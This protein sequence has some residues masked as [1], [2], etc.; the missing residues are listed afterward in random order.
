MLV[1][2]WMD[3]AAS[4]QFFVDACKQS[5]H[6][7]APDLRGFGQSEW[8][9]EG[10]SGYWFADY[11]ADL[12]AL[13]DEVSP[14]APVHL[15][16]HS[17]GGNIVSMYAGVR[18]HR[19]AKLISLDGFGVPR[20]T[21]DQAPNKLAAWLDAVRAPP[22]LQSYASL[23]RVAERLVKNNPRLTPERAA[24]I[25]KHWAEP[26]ADGSYA[27]RADPAH[28]LPFPTV[29][30]LE[31]SLAIW[32]KVSAP[33]LWVGATDSQIVQWLGYGRDNASEMG[34]DSKH[35]PEFRERLAAFANVRFE[36]IVDAG[37]MLHHDQPEATA[38]LVESFLLTP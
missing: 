34:E 1:H 30:R 32:R 3:V 7:I 33:T 21:T 19:V 13:L 2:G 24:F 18:P 14:N 27:L 23:E 36:M 15:L 5:W 26:L 25:A 11:L 16:G 28:K 20:G 9:R 37:H 12:D 22:R 29:Y 4:F 6:F 35:T 17:L 10:V 38:Q 31:E 8:S